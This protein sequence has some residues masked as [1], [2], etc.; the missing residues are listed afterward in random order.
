[1]RWNPAYVAHVL[2]PDYRHASAHLAEHFF[3]ALVAHARGLA[4]GGVP[5]ALEAAEALGRARLEGLPAYDPEVEDVFFAIDAMLARTAPLAAGALRTALSRNDLDMTVYRMSARERL[6]GLAGRLDALR[7]AL[8]ELAEREAQTVVVAHTHHQPAQPTTLG[9]YLAGFENVLSRDAERAL[10]A[11]TRLNL[12]PLG[13]VALAGTSHPVDREHAAELLGFDRPVENTYDAVSASDWQSELA[14]VAATLATGL[15]RLLY[16]LL[17]WASVGLVTIGD[18]LVQGSSVMPQKRNPVALEHARAKLSRAL[19]YASAVQLSGHNVPFG[20][21]N[22]PGPDVQEPLW[23]MWRELEHALELLTLSVMTLVVDR[24]A[25]LRQVQDGETML[26][27]LADALGRAVPLSFREAHGLAQRLLADLRA[28]GRTLASATA[29][30]V[31]RA[32]GLAVEEEVVRSALDPREFVTRR[33]TLGGP[34]PEVLRQHLGFAG[35]RLAADR[36]AGRALGDRLARS[37]SRLG[38]AP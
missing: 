37:R 7:S 13:A 2:E 9:H 16:D 36:A 30:D 10:G 12:C 8:L 17:F 3:D 11:W 34:S 22:D 18:G 5:H 24:A 4:L 29:E 32:T 19:G 28:Q 6:L 27:E 31:R 15:S 26:T 20:D 1:M 33:R 35:G 14:G 25:W 21:I 38:E 23:A